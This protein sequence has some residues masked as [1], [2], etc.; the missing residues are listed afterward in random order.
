MLRRPPKSTRT[1]TLFPYT[2]LFLT[3]PFAHAPIKGHIHLSHPKGADHLGNAKAIP[4]HNFMVGMI[5]NRHDETQA[6]IAIRRRWRM[7]RHE[8][9]YRL[10]TMGYRRP[11]PTD[12]SQ[13]LRTPESLADSRRG[14][15]KQ[16]GST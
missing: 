5:W 14:T 4:P 1:A 15:G 7:R 3:L 6:V 11:A 9:A 16:R 8:G 2:T 12:V 13:P 10:Q